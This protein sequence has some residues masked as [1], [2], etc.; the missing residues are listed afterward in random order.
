MDKET[1]INITEVW[2]ELMPFKRLQLDIVYNRIPKEHLSSEDLKNPE[3]AKQIEQHGY[4]DITNHLPLN[5]INAL[6]KLVE[7]EYVE[8]KVHTMHQI[9]FSYEAHH[10]VPYSSLLH[11][12]GSS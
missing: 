4:F 9:I 8:K 1:A 6:E 7:L 3:V 10:Y 12:L 2:R 11:Q 5:K